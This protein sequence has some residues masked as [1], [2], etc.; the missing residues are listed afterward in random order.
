MSSS[1]TA[2]LLGYVDQLVRTTRDGLIQWQRPNPTTFSWSTQGPPIGAVVIQ[3]VERR[4]LPTMPPEDYVLQVLDPQYGT[5]PR[6][7][8]EG[9][10]DR[11]VFEKLKE[12]YETIASSISRKNLDFFRSILPKPG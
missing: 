8:L 12:L 10:K 2:E 5:S 9:E 7:M 11:V 3:R 6:V 4:R 1:E